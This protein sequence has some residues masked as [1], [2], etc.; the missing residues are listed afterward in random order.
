MTDTSQRIPHDSLEWTRDAILAV[1]GCPE[2]GNDLVLS[3][4]GEC[5]KCG[6]GYSV[7]VNFDV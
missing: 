4:E 1:E 2:C 3:E 5:P 6:T 7:E